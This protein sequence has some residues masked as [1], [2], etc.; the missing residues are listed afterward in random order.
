MGV[1]SY[2]ALAGVICSLIYYAAA[3]VAAL[4]FA[5]RAGRPASSMPNPAPLVALLKPLHG[6]S[7]TLA[8]NL[9]SFFAL[10]YPTKEIVFGLTTDADPAFQVVSALQSRAKQTRIKLCFG[11]TPGAANHKVAKLMKMVQLASEAEVFVLSD[12]DVRVE[13][14]HLRRVVAELAADERIGVVTCLYRALAERRLGARLDALFVNTDFAPMAMLSCA[15]ERMAHAFGATIA[16][17][18]DVLRVLDDFGA[19][20]DLLA[21]DFFIGKIAADKGYEVKLSSSL[22]T[23]WSEEQGLRDFWQHQLRWAR[24][25]RTVRPLSLATIVIHGHLWALLLLASTGA[26]QFSI[27][28]AAAILAARAAFGALM[29]GKV[30]KL[31]WR[32]SD[33]GLMFVKDFFMSAIWFASL[34]S[35]EVTWGGRKFHLT[36]HGKMVEI[37]P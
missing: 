16:V 3:A 12:A 1:L 4:R 29:L 36:D 28:L 26:A 32:L 11:E 22:V 9:E 24:T 23:V 2:L 10:E 21:D 37:K 8:Q 25:Y 30:L 15:F 14:D 35:N 34:L 31:P 33:L 20:K 27:A 13:P 18:R 17:K 6:A 5:R 7:K 19:L